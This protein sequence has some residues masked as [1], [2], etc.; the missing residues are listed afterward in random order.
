[1]YS[2]EI[3]VKTPFFEKGTSYGNPFDAIINKCAEYKT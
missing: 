1:M 2:T 3:V